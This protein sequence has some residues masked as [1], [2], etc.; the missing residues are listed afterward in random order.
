MNL[1]ALAQDRESCWTFVNAVMN[2]RLKMRGRS[3]L[4]KD[5]LDSQE[6][7]MELIR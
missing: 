4:D 1:N 6:G 2:I 3:W 7:S 5:L